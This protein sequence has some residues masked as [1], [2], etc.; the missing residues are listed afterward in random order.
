MAVLKKCSYKFIFFIILIFSELIVVAQSGEIDSLRQL[1]P[2]KKGE[3]LAQVYLELSKS[4]IY[5]RPAETTGYALKALALSKQ[6]KSLEKECYADLLA[7]AGYIYCGNFDEGKDYVDKGLGLAGKLNNTEYL[8]FGM[9]MLGAYFLSKGD[10]DKSMSVFKDVLARA[11]AAGLEERAATIQ[12]NIGSLLTSKGERTKGLRYL[13]E[14]LKYFEKNGT[15]RVISR[16]FNNIAV[17]YHA[18]KDYDKALEYYEKTLESYQALDDVIGQVVVLNNIGEIYKDKNNY[19]KA[20][21]YYQQTIELADRDEAGDY[22]KAYGWIGEAETYCLMKEDAF[23]IEKARLALDGFQQAKMKEGIARSELILGRAYILQKNYN[24]ALKHL[25]RSSELAQ[26]TGIIDLEQSVYRYKAEA[27]AG[28]KFYQEAYMMLREYTNLSDTLYKEEQMKELAQLRNELEITDKE[29]EIELL[30]KDNQIK[31]LYIRKQ[32]IQNRFLFLILIFLVVLF[33]IMFGYLRSR[34]K[35]N[36]LLQEKNR[37]INEQ[38]VEL[39]RVNETKDKFLSI[40]SHDLRNPIGAF[41][42]VVGQLADFPEMFSEE[43]RQQIIHELRGESENTYFLLDNLL[44]WARSQK[45]NMKYSPEQLQLASLV[46]NNILLHSRLAER[47]KISLI[48]MVPPDLIVC[49]DHNMINLVLRNLISNAIKFTGEH[50]RIT[51]SSRDIGEF[52]KLSVT[53]SGIGIP[54]ESIPK[55]FNETDHISTYGTNNEKGSGLGLLLCREFVETNGGTISVR[56]VPGKG[57]TFSFTL[58]KG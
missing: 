56:S 23:A 15:P 30:Q 24:E 33:V 52:I 17:N 10:Y 34:K 14:A 3:E 41:K 57:S 8:C 18:W 36:E 37:R 27:Y 55:L 32:E 5:V 2:L 46:D 47:K 48:S 11:E 51:L 45:N 40:I 53:D 19:Q 7:G 16:I 26:N 21:A 35:A 42:D 29:N 54:E 13:L 39:I 49:A 43:L 20:L 25:G 4:F 44:S 28:K 22:Y 1:I 12:M 38:H 31:G 6:Q 50:G 58:K 9:N